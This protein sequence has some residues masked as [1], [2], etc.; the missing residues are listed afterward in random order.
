[1]IGSSFAPQRFVG[2]CEGVLLN[3]LTYIFDVEVQLFFHLQTLIFGMYYEINIH[4][5]ELTT[6]HDICYLDPKQ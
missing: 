2:Y 4:E 1:M 5:H 6:N 3:L